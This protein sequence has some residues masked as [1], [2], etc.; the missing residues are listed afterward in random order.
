MLAA[1]AVRCARSWDGWGRPAEAAGELGRAGGTKALGTCRLSR[2][3]GELTDPG[4]ELSECF[5]EGL[6][7]PLPDPSETRRVTLRCCS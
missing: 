6:G 4:L 2:R 5:S 7:S 1:A 3:S